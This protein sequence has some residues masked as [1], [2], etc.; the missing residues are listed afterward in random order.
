MSSI[1]VSP[2]YGRDYK[3]KKAL[4]TDWEANKDFIVEDVMNNWILLVQWCGKPI[5]KQ[6]AVKGGIITIK[7]RYGKMRKVTTFPA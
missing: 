4:V 3:S 1:T 7:A 6:D 2:A 5:N